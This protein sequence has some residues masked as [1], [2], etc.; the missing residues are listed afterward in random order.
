MKLL[1]RL[2]YGTI[3]LVF[4]SYLTLPNSDFP[5]PPEGAV[6]SLEP[7]DSETSLRRAY[8]TDLSRSEVINHYKSEFVIEILG[9][10]LANYKLNY[11]PE[12]AY[13]LIRDQTRSTYLEEVIY[14]LRESI[15][16]NGFEPSSAK[17][18]I[19]IGSVEYSQKITVRYYPSD[20]VARVIIGIVVS[21]TLYVVLSVFVKELTE[22]SKLLKLKIWQ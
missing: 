14:P 17:D 13:G 21:I 16:I 19:I 11:P 10:K 9:V 8:F 7:A 15:F 20:R 4:I 1:I 5:K 22:L 3:A 18:K 6:Q 2:T 12:E